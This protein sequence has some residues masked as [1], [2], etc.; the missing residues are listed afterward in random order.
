[1][2]KFLLTSL[3]R[4]V[5]L[6]RNI[7]PRSSCTNLAL[8]LRARSVPTRT[9]SQSVWHFSIQ[10]TSRSINY[11]KLMCFCN[12]SR[13]NVSWR[14][15]VDQRSN[16]SVLVGRFVRFLCSRR[17]GSFFIQLRIILMNIFLYVDHECTLI[18]SQLIIDTNIWMTKLTIL[19]LLG[20]RR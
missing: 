17:I 6:Q 18:S 10:K 1:M 4:Y 19:P 20:Q 8:R 2:I 3:A 16:P 13:I 5:G 7:G 12:F 14:L 11:K 15:E 9:V